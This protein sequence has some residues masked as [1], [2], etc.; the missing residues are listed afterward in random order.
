MSS[1][2]NVDVQNTPLSRFKKSM[3]I[4]YEKWHD[5]IGYD[6]ESLIEATPEER[7]TIANILI[8]RDLDWRDI[9]A[10][11][12]VDTPCAREGLKAAV[13]GGS[14]V[15]QMAV[16]R[17][18]PELIDEDVRTK[19]IVRALR[20]VTIYGGLSQTLDE[21]ESHHP[22]EV[23][24]ELLRGLLEREGDVAVHFAAMLFFIHGKADTPFDMEQRP[25]FLRFNTNVVSDRRRVFHELCKVIG[26]NPSEYF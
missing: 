14:S 24:N 26:V 13:L 25:F 1:D 11:A 6:L 22:P 9:E 17:Y 4:D 2:K 10:L 16:L 20:S 3:T 12:A 15:V 21:V 7:D 23:V 19:L 18:A 5:G 8:A